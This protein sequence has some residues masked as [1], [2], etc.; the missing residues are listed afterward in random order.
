MHKSAGVRTSAFPGQTYPTSNSAGT[1][2]LPAS[3]RLFYRNGNQWQP[4][5]ADLPRPQADELQSLE[6]TPVTTSSVR[7]EVVPQKNKT[8]GLMEWVVR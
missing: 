7:L 4:I 3:Y 5:N 6:F 1:W 8:V 2:A